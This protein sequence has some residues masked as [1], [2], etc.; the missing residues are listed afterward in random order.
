VALDELLE[1]LSVASTTGIDQLGIG[2]RVTARC[3]IAP[4]TLRSLKH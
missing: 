1:C 2:H 3:P 4:G